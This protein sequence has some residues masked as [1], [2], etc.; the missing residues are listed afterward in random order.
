MS[1]TPSSPK[2]FFSSKGE[3]ALSDLSHVKI[4]TAY[5]LHINVEK[6]LS[7]KHSRSDKTV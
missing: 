7:K 3:K 6:Y 5:E 2:K 1:K 4:V